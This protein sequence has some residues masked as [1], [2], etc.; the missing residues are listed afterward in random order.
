MKLP[1]SFEDADKVIFYN[2]GSMLA[3]TEAP[4]WEGPLDG[5][6]HLD[7]RT[8]APGWDTHRLEQEWR[9]WLGENEIQP[10]RPAPHFVKFCKTWF[11][12]R[13]RP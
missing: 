6:A 5:E 3:T 9:K 12:K 4:L 11:E 8:V 7:A 2:R 13:G 1:E 10:T